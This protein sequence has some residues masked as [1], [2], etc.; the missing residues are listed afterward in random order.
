MKKKQSRTKQAQYTPRNTIIYLHTQFLLLRNTM[1]RAGRRWWLIDMAQGKT[2]GWALI[3]AWRNVAHN[4]QLQSFQNYLEFMYI[5]FSTI[6]KQ[7]LNLEVEQQ[8]RF[9]CAVAQEQ[10]MS[11]FR[12]EDVFMA[13]SCYSV[14]HQSEMDSRYGLDVQCGKDDREKLHLSLHFFFLFRN[15]ISLCLICLVGSISLRSGMM[16]WVDLAMTGYA[17]CRLACASSLWELN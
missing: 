16:W 9:G 13:N 14:W 5:C 1:A 10:K 15:S 8:K 4:I 17:H 3:V 6:V 11:F 7:L 12:S 2:L